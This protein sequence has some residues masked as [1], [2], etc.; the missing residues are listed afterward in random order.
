MNYIDGNKTAW[1]EVFNKRRPGWGDKNHEALKSGKFAFFNDD[2]KKELE[3]LDLGGKAVAQFCCNNGREL[4]SIL[5][6]GA[7]CAVGFDIADNILEQAKE[8]AKKSGITNCKFIACDILDIPESY[9]ESFDLVFFTIGAITWFR[10][11][12]KLFY[13]VSKCLKT[14]GLLL[15]NDYHPIINMLPVPG[16][17]EFDPDDLNKIAFSYF[18][19]EPWF[20]NKMDYISDETTS[21]TFTSFS[22]TMSDIVNALSENGIRIIKLGEY[23]YDVGMTDVYD[24]KGFP[25]SYILVAEKLG[26]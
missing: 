12:D 5:D 1:E 7:A 9:H 11:L 22:H 10:E 20:E 17:D 26:Y 15:I 16:E 2:V 6:S 3:A 23:D 8:T 19:K 14:G 21:G 24:G 4:L 18:E 25:L 13:V